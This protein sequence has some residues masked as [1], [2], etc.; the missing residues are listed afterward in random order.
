[1]VVKPGETLSSEDVRRHC[2]K[3]LGEFKVPKAVRFVDAL[4]KSDRG[5]IRREALKEIWARDDG[6]R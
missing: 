1:M 4:P 2:A 5:K 6:A 3:T